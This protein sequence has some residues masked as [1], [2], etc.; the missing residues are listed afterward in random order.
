MSVVFELKLSLTLCL[1]FRHHASVP[2]GL[3]IR[4]SDY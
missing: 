1:T 3:V 2:R 4:V